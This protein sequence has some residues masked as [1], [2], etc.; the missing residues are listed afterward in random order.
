MTLEAVNCAGNGFSRKHS[1]QVRAEKVVRAL[2]Y[3]FLGTLDLH[4]SFSTIAPIFR[5][6]FFS[7]EATLEIKMLGS[8][9]FRPSVETDWGNVNFSATI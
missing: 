8:Q 7:S 5:Y 9:S 6:F 4:L 2:L 1:T 3:F